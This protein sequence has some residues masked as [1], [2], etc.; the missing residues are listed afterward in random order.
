MDKNTGRVRRLAV[1]E[2]ANLNGCGSDCW[3]RTDH[4]C[5]F[6]GEPQQGTPGC[7][8]FERVVLPLDPELE[9]VYLAERRAAAGGY[10]LTPLQAEMVKESA[11]PPQARVACMKCGRVFPAP[12]NRQQYC[13]EC[14]DTARRERS[15][16][17]KLKQRTKGA[18]VTL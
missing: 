6:F 16:A 15:R 18:A 9:A 1:D 4:K 11:R 3:V 2:C 12:S 7:G 10:A 5:V 8:Y 13:P 17:R 14:R